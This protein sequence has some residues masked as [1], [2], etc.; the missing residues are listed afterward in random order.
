MCNYYQ[1]DIRKAGRERDYYAFDEF[2]ETPR[3]IYPDVL[4]PVVRARLDGAR[5]WQVMR[6]GFPPPPNL[7]TRR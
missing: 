7:G 1:S 6:W 3:D 5:E 4:A 2:S